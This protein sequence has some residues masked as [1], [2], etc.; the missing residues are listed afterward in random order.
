MIKR[1][2]IAHPHPHLDPASRNVAIRFTS[3]SRN[4]LQDIIA[5]G[6]RRIYLGLYR[7]VLTTPLELGGD[8]KGSINKVLY[9]HG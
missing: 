6:F 3:D 7:R 5:T 9:E 1:D 4:S 2:G 8:L